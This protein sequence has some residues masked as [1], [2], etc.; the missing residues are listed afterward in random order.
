M[1]FPWAH[2]PLWPLLFFNY[3]PKFCSSSF[4]FLDVLNGFGHDLSCSVPTPIGCTPGFLFKAIQKKGN[5]W[6]VNKFRAQVLSGDS[7]RITQVIRG[8]FEGCALSF[9][10]SS[11]KPRR[12]KL[13]QWSLELP[14]LSQKHQSIWTIQG[15]S[16]VGHLQS[17]IHIGVGSKFEV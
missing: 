1:S 8:R 10:A 7:K 6:W 4:W 14:T 13:H 17:E 2:V 12:S 9:P 11:I 5:S 3:F 16:Q 15:E